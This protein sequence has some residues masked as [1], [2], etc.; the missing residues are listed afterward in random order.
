MATPDSSP[1]KMNQQ[2]TEGVTFKSIIIAT[3]LIPLNCYWVIEMEVIRYLSRGLPKKEIA[4]I[5]SLS[6]STVNNHTANLMRK[7][8]IH[9]RVE[10]VRFAIR[11][12]LADP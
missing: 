10:L 6:V 1:Q 11:E 5:M 2:L 4:R 3:L 7:L 8:E 9:D 12:G